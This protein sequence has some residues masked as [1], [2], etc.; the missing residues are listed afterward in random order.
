MSRTVKLLDLEFTVI[1][2]DGSGWAAGAM[3][4]ADL[5]NSKIHICSEMEKGMKDS[6]LLHEVLHIIADIQGVEMSEQ[7]TSCIAS[8]FYSLIVSNKDLIKGMFKEW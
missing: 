3:G 2:D 1:D 7:D 4:R 5:K 6:V 8:G